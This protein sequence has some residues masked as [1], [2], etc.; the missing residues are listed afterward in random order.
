MI[1]V[2]KLLIFSYLSLYIMLLLFYFMVI[3]GYVFVNQEII[4]GDNAKLFSTFK[5]MTYVI[6]FYTI[7]GVVFNFIVLKTNGMCCINQKIM[8]KDD[9]NDNN[10]I[11]DNV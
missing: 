10:N 9:I 1:N 5:L 7:F 4:N 2:K 8:P 11:N 3:L 6:L